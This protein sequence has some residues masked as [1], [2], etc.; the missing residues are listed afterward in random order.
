MPALAA[1][2]LAVL[3]VA[4]GIAADPNALWHIVGE[5]CVPDEKLQE[6]CQLGPGHS[7]VYDSLTNGVPVSVTAERL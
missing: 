3:A 5:Q 4:R 2:C 7:P 6:L 1:V